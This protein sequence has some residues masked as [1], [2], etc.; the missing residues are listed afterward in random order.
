MGIAVQK[1]L[2]G[3]HH[4]TDSGVASWYDFAL[5]IYE[6][7]TLLG[8]LDKKVNILPISAEN[9]PTPAKR[10][11][12]S[13]LDKSSMSEALSRIPPHWRVNLRKM[14]REVKCEE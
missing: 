4:W 7:A 9:Y 3:L 8:L 12:Y 2:V 14:L 1:D 13:V 10:P 11:P 5:A 6:E